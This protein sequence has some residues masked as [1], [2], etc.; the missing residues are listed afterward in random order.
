MNFDTI[1]KYSNFISYQRIKAIKVKQ[2]FDNKGPKSNKFQILGKGTNTYQD[3]LDKKDGFKC[4]CVKTCNG[5][6]NY[7]P[8]PSISN[9]VSQSYSATSIEE[10]ICFKGM[11]KVGQGDLSGSPCRGY[12]NGYTTYVGSAF[13]YISPNKTCEDL[14]IAGLF[15][16]VTSPYTIVLVLTGDTFG[17]TIWTCLILTQGSTTIRL[18]KLSSTAVKTDTEIIYTWDNVNII[19]KFTTGKQWCVMLTQ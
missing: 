14:L 10:C 13:G 17:D 1:E 8:I 19:E 3:Y 18:R 6:C 15:Y 2:K 11:L 7:A 9:S 12:T 16:V 4:C 5:C